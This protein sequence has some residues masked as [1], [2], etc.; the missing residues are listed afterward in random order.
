MT[1]QS[2]GTQEGGD[3]TL[4]AGRERGPR[5]TRLADIDSELEKLAMDSRCAPQRVGNAHLTNEL[6]DL[7]WCPR[8]ATTRSRFPTP[9]AAKSRSMPPNHRFRPNDGMRIHHIRNEAMEDDKDQSV[10]VGKSEPHWR[11]ATKNIELV[12]QDKNLSLKHRFRA[13]ASDQVAQNQFERI[14]HPA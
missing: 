2:G 3:G 14:C 5:H 10:N 8:A 1:G 7:R 9:E 4:R 11:L 12:T 13:Q 6:A